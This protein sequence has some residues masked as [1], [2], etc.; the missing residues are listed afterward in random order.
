[1]KTK[2]NFLSQGIRITD[3]LINDIIFMCETRMKETYFTRIGNNKMTFKSIVVFI[4]NFVKRSIQLELDD[5]FNDI[6]VADFNVTKQA[7][8]EARQ[9]LSPTA[10]IK[11]SDEIIKWFYKD[12]D[13]KLY[14]GYRLLSI[15]GTILE[16]N[17]TENLRDKFGYIENQTI[18]VARAKATGLYDIENDM[19]LTSVIGKYKAGER[20]Q[21]EELINKLEQI[22]FSNDLILFD[23][24]FPSREFISFIES[25]KIHY[26]MRVSSAFLKDVVNAPNADQII[27]A[28]Y[29]GKIIKMRVLKFQ[30]DSGITEILITNIFDESFSVAD[31]K[32][33]YFKRWGIEVKYNELKNRLQVENFSGETP[34]AI[35]QDF[36]AT[37]YLSNMVALAKMDANAIILEKNKDKNLKYEY[38]VNTNILIGKLKNSLVS[39]LLEHRPRKRSK[40]LKKILK[41]ISRNIIP[42]RPGR[43]FARRMTVRANKYSLNKK[44]AL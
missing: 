44:R 42:I 30:L 21:A 15:D 16:I 6:T 35:E 43:K 4:L 34:I 23:R 8:S 28:K 39:M 37:M 2:R 33:L 14:K 1:M 13:F 18:K 26:L 40:I 10:F 36:Y 11:M 19:L 7:F 9:K 29:K 25:K 31:F 24:G 17:N 41:E 38:K 20:A 12:T 3:A 32:V 27:E 5:F 22:G